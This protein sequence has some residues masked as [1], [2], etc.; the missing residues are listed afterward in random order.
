M[1]HNTFI[2]SKVEIMKNK[3]NDP[4]Q[5]WS[6]FLSRRCITNCKALFLGEM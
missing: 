4:H 5:S 3:G 6:W 1:H 2:K